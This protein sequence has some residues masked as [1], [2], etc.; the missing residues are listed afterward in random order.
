MEKKDRYEFN[1]E[2]AYQLVAITDNNGNDKVPTRSFYAE[3]LN[4]I[5]T[6]FEYD[7]EVH[8]DG[9]RLYMR[10]VRNEH[11]MPI[12][13]GLHTSPIHKVEDT[14]EGLIIYTRNSIYKFKSAEINE[15]PYKEEASLI[16]LFLSADEAYYF[17]KGRYYN[18]DK[19]PQDLERHVHLGMTQDSVLIAPKE[20]PMDFVCRFFPNWQD[21]CFYDTIYGQQDY[22]VPMLI[23]N[24]G[25]R[26][27]QV[28]FERYHK[29]WTIA[30]NESKRIVPFTP[31]GADEG[32]D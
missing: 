22:S 28:R 27:F 18:E 7:E 19:K 2:K 32:R 31:E 17:T 1:Y 13:K 29:V 6:E 25:I 11:G 21:I 23:H 10:F 12:N 8:K 26:P 5:A 9:Y 3:R 30:P 20:N 4:C 14:P 24:T 15:V 16:E